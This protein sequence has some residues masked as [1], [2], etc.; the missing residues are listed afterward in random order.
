[1][2]SELRVPFWWVDLTRNTPCAGA[3]FDWLA[4]STLARYYLESQ[5]QRL[6]EVTVKRSLNAEQVTDGGLEDLE[7]M[8]RLKRLRLGHSQVTDEGVNKLQQV[9]PGCK[10]D[11]LS[12]YRISSLP[13]EGR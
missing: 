13:H 2:L 12:E 9:L 1:M 8:T 5:R 10:T 4:S 7:A 6:S 3:H 11:V